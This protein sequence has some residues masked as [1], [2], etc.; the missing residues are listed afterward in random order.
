MHLRA[1]SYDQGVHAFGWSVV[2]FFYMWLGA[3]AIGAPK[4][5]S[6]VV[7]L[8]LAAGIFLLV[9]TRGGESPRGTR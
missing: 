5:T 6:L 8:V 9:R 4:G 1:P 3:L 2:F 7:S